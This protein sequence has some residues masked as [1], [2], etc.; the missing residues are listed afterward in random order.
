MRPLISGAEA[1]AARWRQRQVGERLAYRRQQTSLFTCILPPAVSTTTIIVGWDDCVGSG[2][3]SRASFAHFT[4]SLIAA[5]R[6]ATSLSRSSCQ[7]AIASVSTQ[8]RARPR[9]RM[10]AIRCARRCTL[11]RSA[12]QACAR[13][14]D[15]SARLGTRARK[16]MRITR[17]RSRDRLLAPIKV[18]AERA[19]PRAL[20]GRRRATLR[21][22]RVGR[23]HSNFARFFIV[24]LSRARARAMIMQTPPPRDARARATMTRRSAR[25]LDVDRRVEARARVWSHEH[26]TSA[27]GELRARSSSQQRVSVR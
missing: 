24:L 14:V 7:P 4:P 9:A 1:A 8:A 19:C 6:S 23:V 20:N 15:G 22:Y 5:A 21:V 3:R 10:A 12:A 25:G 18:E 13:F 27:D 26:A 2:A 17:A 16:K 11:D